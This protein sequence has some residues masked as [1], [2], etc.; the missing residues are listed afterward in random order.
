MVIDNWSKLSEVS[1]SPGEAHSNCQLVLAH[2]PK[3][4]I[5]LIIY[6]SCQVCDIHLQIDWLAAI[7][8]KQ[9]LN[10]LSNFGKIK[11]S[12]GR[13]ENTLATVIWQ[14]N[15]IKRSPGTLSSKNLSFLLLRNRLEIWAVIR[16][17]CSLVQ[18]ELWSVSA[19]KNIFAI[20]WNIIGL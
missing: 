3:K 9:G 1:S 10:C 20:F 16:W 14:H 19:C 8:V 18:V 4:N 17:P 6:V 11:P 5:V 12:G 7:L 2:P 15:L 13:K